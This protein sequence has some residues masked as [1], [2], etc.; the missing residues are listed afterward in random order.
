MTGNFED[1]NSANE[2]FAGPETFMNVPFSTAPEKALAAILGVPFDAGTSPTRVGSRTG[3]AAI[4]K[5]S[6]LLDRHQ[7]P[8]TLYSPLEQL[9]VVDCGDVSVIPSA[10]A[11]SFEKIEAA[12][13]IV[14]N[15]GAAPLGF[16]GDG[17][18]SLPLLRAVK[19]KHPDFAVL[20]IDAHTDTY[21]GEGNAVHDRYNTATTFTRAAEEGLVDL[22]NS[23]HIGI[24][25]TASQSDILE[26]TRAQCYQ[27]I[28]SNKLFETGLAATAEKL[29]D[30]L[31]GKS[32]YLCFDM[33]FFDP[34]CAPGVCSPTW[35]G[36]TAR[37][38]LGFLQNLSGIDFIG[39]DINTVSPPH[40]VG[41]MTALLAAT[42][43][44][45]ILTLFCSSPKILAKI[46]T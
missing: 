3:P 21:R 1:Q 16:G 43:A 35:G 13:S 2:P 37:E 9:S 39:A 40:D 22:K 27:V 30:G 24:R 11:A 8:Q 32:V 10:V 33:D 14:L 34:S 25:G 46:D 45:E 44:F 28:E 31:T 12:A 20:H 19:A 6:L 36:A 38:G 42:V 5:Q 15:S 18:I 23:Y 4:R 41:G 7:P 17:M 29:R 26:H